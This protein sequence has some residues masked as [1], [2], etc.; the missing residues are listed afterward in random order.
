MNAAATSFLVLAAICAVIHWWSVATK[1]R[2]LLLVTKPLTMVLLIGLAASIDSTAGASRAWFIAALILSLAGDVF[3]M[4][5][6][7]RFVAGLASF[8]GAHL[9]YIVGLILAGFAPIAALVALAVAIG[10]F[11]VIGRPILTGA[12]AT[13]ERLAI[14]VAAYIAVISAMVVAAAATT[15]L[16]AVA[17][18]VSFFGSD[19]VLGWNRFVATIPRGR[20][21]TMITYH[22]GQTLLVL[23]LIAL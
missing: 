18:A 4:L 19:A 9:A 15:T 8:L 22:T 10:L 6:P 21:I 11:P 23:S 3:L 16:L 13:D 5:E 12:R 17:G 2:S 7:D 1:R 14:P 20:L